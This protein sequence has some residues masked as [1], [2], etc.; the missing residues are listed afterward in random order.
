MKNIIITIFGILLISCSSENL[1]VIFEPILK[2]E[3]IVCDISEAIEIQMIDSIGLMHNE[4]MNLIYLNFIFDSLNNGNHESLMRNAFIAVNYRNASD[5][6]DIFF[7]DTI[8]LLNQPCPIKVRDYYDLIINII[9]TGS[10]YA[11]IVSGLEAL[12]IQLDS[13]DMIS[14]EEKQLVLVG[15]S[16]ANHSSHYWLPTSIGGC[17]DGYDFLNRLFPNKAVSDKTK[18]IIGSD[19]FGG[20]SGGLGWCGAAMFGPVGLGAFV[21]GIL[22]GAVSGSATAAALSK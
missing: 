20:L 3:N 16:I 17:G 9:D 4:M 18:N 6:Y 12:S 22:W 5:E 2:N 11:N 1:D 8:P 19:V 10:T 21:G 14:F 15:L 13:D 7:Y